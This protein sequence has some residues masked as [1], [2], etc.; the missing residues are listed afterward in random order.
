MR[1]ERDPMN[2][3]KTTKKAAALKYDPARNDAPEITALGQGIV[4]EK[5]L[6]E[7]EK[8][9][10]PIVEDEQSA[11][12]LSKFAVGDAIPPALYSVVAE[13]LV[14]LYRMDKTMPQRRYRL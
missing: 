11:E 5:I 1:F 12:I 2:N 8:N 10:V 3:G 9:G 14:F 13:M 4:A 6:E 7:A